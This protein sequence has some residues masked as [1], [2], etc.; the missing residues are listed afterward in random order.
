MRNGHDGR[1][2]RSNDGGA[3]ALLRDKTRKLGKK[4]V[5]Q[6]TKETVC[7]I[8]CTGRPE[9]ETHWSCRG[10]ARRVGIGHTSA[11]LIL[12]GHG[13]RPHLA[14]GRNYSDDPGSEAKL[15]DVVGLYL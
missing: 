4:P 14:N 9:G 3:G 11:N 10:V 13:L 12:C 15:R 1:I 2:S 5:S 7:R 6:Q 8:V